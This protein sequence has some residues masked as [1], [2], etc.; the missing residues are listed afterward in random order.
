MHLNL[1]Q[2]SLLFYLVSPGYTQSQWPTQ[3]YEYPRAGVQVGQ[4]WDSFNGQG[5]PSNC[6]KVDIVPLERMSFYSNVQ[7]VQSSYSL[8]KKV[9]T[10]VSASYN[11]GVGGASGSVSSSRSSAINSDFQN[12]LFTFESANGSTFAVPPQQG[13]QSRFEANKSTTDL[14]H[15]I[16]S[17]TAQENFVESLLAR[18]PNVSGSSF[19]LQEHAKMLLFDKDGTVRKNASGQVD[20]TAFRKQC[21]DGFVS[22]I[23]RGSRIHLLL[24]QKYNSRASKETLA[25]SLSASGYGASGSASYSSSTSEFTGRNQLGYTVFQEGGIPQAPVALVKTKDDATRMF[26]V[27]EILPKADQ[28]LANPTAFRV[29]V[30]SYANFVDEIGASLPSP[31]GLFTVGDY[32][33]ALTDIYRLLGSIIASEVAGENRFEK[34]Q[35]VGPFDPR[36]LQIYGGEDV[37]GENDLTRLHDQMLADLVFL[38]LILDECHRIKSDCLLEKAAFGAAVRFAQFSTSLS[39]QLAGLKS[40][41]DAQKERVTMMK[42]DPEG[43]DKLPREEENLEDIKRSI[44]AVEVSQTSAAEHAQFVDKDGRIS[45]DFFLRFYYYLANIPLPRVAYAGIPAFAE[46]SSLMISE[47]T[48]DA[49]IIAKGL[50]V[51]QQLTRA[52]LA[53]RLIPWRDFFCQE[54]KGSRLCVADDMLLDVGRTSGQQAVGKSHFMLKKTPPRPKQVPSYSPRPCSERVNPC[55]T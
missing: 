16:D 47:K 46:M 34:N 54:Q 15:A 6:V 7:Q 19:E 55:P 20:I 10:S 43:Q 1:L 41:S 13:E 36:I 45:D 52:N 32:Y 5:A 14:M 17:H 29:E 42:A 25:A 18:P 44:R 26:D 48:T 50:T 38:E 39:V 40:Q 2:L 30:T 53:F 12:F 11:G 49:E 21:G 51:G 31:A 9:T 24:T 27:N 22:A 23:H 37:N 8:I 4:G 3:N 35:P 28:L 33:I